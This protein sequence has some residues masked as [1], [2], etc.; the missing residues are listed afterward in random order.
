MILVITGFERDPK[1]RINKL[2]GQNPEIGR[3]LS[4]YDKWWY[5]IQ[6]ELDPNRVSP[7][8]GALV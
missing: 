7:E 4:N 5:A 1:A 6:K 2:K 3:S 8:G